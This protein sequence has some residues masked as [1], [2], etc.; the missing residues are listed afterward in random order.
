MGGVKKQQPPATP[1]FDSKCLQRREVAVLSAPAEIP[2]VNA[3]KKGPWRL[4][5]TCVNLPA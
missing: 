4:G 1:G 5:W 2:H 3:I